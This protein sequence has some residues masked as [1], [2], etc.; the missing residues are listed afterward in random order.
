MNFSVGHDIES[1]SRVERL[2]GN[3]H[4]AGRI[5][6]PSELEYISAS[7]H[8]A[9]SAAGIYCAKEAVAK[10]LERGF[11]GMLPE[12]IVIS[13]SPSGAPL[14]NFVGSALESYCDRQIRISIS[15]SGDMASA[16]CVIMW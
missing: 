8:P 10:A 5:F 13:H 9:A 12:E 15:H 2:I 14:V 6:A 3:K 11:F 1:I 4:A 7:A 16:F